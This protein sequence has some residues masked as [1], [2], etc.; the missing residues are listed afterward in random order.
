MCQVLPN[1]LE[2]ELCAN[3]FVDWIFHSS[4]YIEWRYLYRRYQ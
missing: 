3:R 2:S 1:N 4:K